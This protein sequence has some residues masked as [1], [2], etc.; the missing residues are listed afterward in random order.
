MIPWYES[1]MLAARARVPFAC[2]LWQVVPSTSTRKSINLDLAR[3]A[4]ILVLYQKATRSS[5][6]SSVTEPSKVHLQNIQTHYSS[7][8]YSHG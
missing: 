6:S 4:R 8:D 2:M 5:K 7:L 1:R 3:A